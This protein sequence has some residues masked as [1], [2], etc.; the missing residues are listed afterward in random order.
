MQ[1]PKEYFDLLNS[2]KLM[3]VATFGEHPWIAWVYYVA[4]DQGNLYFISSPK[5]I[6]GQHI[7]QNQQVS[8]AIAD[9]SQNPVDSKKGIQLFGTVDV[10]SG[11]GKLKWFFKMW[12]KIAPGTTDIL[13]FKT[14]D[15]GKL[16]SNVYRVTPTKIRF[17]NEALYQDAE[18][19]GLFEED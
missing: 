5:T 8:C 4:D 19:E 15:A 16:E 9:T 11:V 10:V 1:L 7:M 14:F 13:N 2:Q 17:F 3:A 18:A 12:A 6:H